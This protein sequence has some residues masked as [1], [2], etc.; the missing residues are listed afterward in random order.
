M[1]DWKLFGKKSM[2]DIKKAE[3]IDQIAIFGSAH[4]S[5]E[6]PLGKEVFEVCK[7]LTEAGYTIVDGGGP[8]VMR[9]ATIGAKQGGGKVIGVTLYPTDMSNFESK[10]PK[11]LIDKEIKN[12][13]RKIRK[14]N[15][16]KYMIFYL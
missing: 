14:M 12:W 4:T 2:A 13:N 3:N 6:G 9:A 1:K 16:Q 5:S 11:N 7:K 15:R 8:G 10:D